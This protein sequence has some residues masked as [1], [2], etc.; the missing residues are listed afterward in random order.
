MTLLRRELGA[1]LR[2]RRV[3][4]QRPLRAVAAAAGVSL[5]YLSEVERGVKEASS[6]LLAAICKALGVRLPELLVEVAAELERLE[7]IIP[8]QVANPVPVTVV[9]AAAPSAQT[10]RAAA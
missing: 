4:Q 3:S 6:E 5:G 10:P 1:A 7:P 8:G 2:R 9:V